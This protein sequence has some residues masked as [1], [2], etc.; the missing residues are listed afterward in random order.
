M[1]RTTEVEHRKHWGEGLGDKTS[2]VGA[3][4]PDFVNGSCSSLPSFKAH[5]SPT[6]VRVHVLTTLVFFDPCPKAHIQALNE[7][8]CFYRVQLRLV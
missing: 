8:V 3:T 7:A 2:Y 5:C 4:E 1:H 6:H